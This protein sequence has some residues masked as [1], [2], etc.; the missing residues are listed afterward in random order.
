MHTYIHTF[1]HT[2][3][4]CNR[5]NCQKQSKNLKFHLW[6]GFKKP[7]KTRSSTFNTGINLQICGTKGEFLASYIHT[8]YIPTYLHAYIPT[9]IHTWSYMHT[10]IRTYVRTYIHTD[11]HTYRHTYRHTDRQ[12][13]RHT[14]I[15][16]HQTCPFWVWKWSETHCNPICSFNCEKEEG[17]GREGANR[18]FS[19]K[20][21][22]NLSG[23][24]PCK[25]QHFLVN[26]SL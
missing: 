25:V 15:H 6:Q 20:W 13:Y 14:Y 12:T 2:Y 19:C 18:T 4:P 11:I 9:C 3:I 8:S 23:K 17:R 26:W 22:F 24:I 7:P 1:I 16:T 10:F 5:N 21:R